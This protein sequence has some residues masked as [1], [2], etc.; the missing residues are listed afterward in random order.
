VNSRVLLIDDEADARAEL[1]WLLSAH[2]TYTIVGEAA[3][4]AAARQLLRAG[5]YD[6]VFLD[7]QLFGGVG[8]DLVPDIAPP[9]RIIFVTAYDRHALRA[10]EVNAL[11]YLLK[12]VAPERFAAALA[13]INAGTPLASLNAQ[14]SPPTLFRADDTVLVHTDAG[15]R[16]L[17][18]TQIAAIFSNENYSDVHLRTHERFLTRRTL[19]SWEDALPAA[20]FRRVHRQALVNL[21][22]IA[23]HRRDTRE[24]AELRV[25]G[26][27]NPVPVSRA[28]L[29]DLRP[30][31]DSL[32]PTPRS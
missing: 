24:T 6:V 17:P 23:S 14:P 10:F 11:D 2:P 1:R 30:L 21:A 12:P 3:T 26:V 18:L 4:F 15:D 28:F 31:L 9:A 7:I 16:F 25:T 22:H 5:G 19:K 20:N 13:R 29:P 32:P 8:F 27:S